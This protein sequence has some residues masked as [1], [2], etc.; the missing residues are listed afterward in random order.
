V[1]FTKGRPSFSHDNNLEQEVKHRT[2]APTSSPGKKRHKQEVDK[3]N[4]L[5][6]FKK[7]S[8]YCYISCAI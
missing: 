3:R 7:S 8:A 4:I 2:D 1:P 6:S 5:L